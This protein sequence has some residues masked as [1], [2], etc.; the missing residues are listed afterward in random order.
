MHTLCSRCKKEINAHTLYFY[1]EIVSPPHAPP[2]SPFHLI[3]VSPANPFT[4]SHRHSSK[5]HNFNPH[6][7]INSPLHPFTPAPLTLYH[8]PLHHYRT[9]PRRHLTP[10]PLPPS[11]F[12]PFTASSVAPSTPPHLRPVTFPPLHPSIQ[13]EIYSILC[14]VLAH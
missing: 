4:H 12:H 10:L 9:S 1:F 8:S 6:L 3:T 5:V 13:L 11:P 7:F 2:H 14:T